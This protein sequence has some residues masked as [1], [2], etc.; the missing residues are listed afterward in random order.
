MIKTTKAPFSLDGASENGL[1]PAI[2][3]AEFAKN[4][5]LSG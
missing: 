2:L 3:D 5:L 4:D 1:N